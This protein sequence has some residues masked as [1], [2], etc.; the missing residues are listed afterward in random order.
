VL[1]LPAPDA[2]DIAHDDR[3]IPDCWEDDVVDAE[4]LASAPFV[5]SLELSSSDEASCE[6]SADGAGDV[7]RPFLASVCVA[8]PLPLLHAP[9]ASPPV[10]AKMHA[11]K[12][13]VAS[14]EGAVRRSSRIASKKKQ[15]AAKADGVAAVQELIARAC[16][17]IAKEGAFD[18]AAK[19]SYLRLFSSQLS[20][21]VIGAIEALIKQVKKSKKAKG[22]GK[23]KGKGKKGSSVSLDIVS[24]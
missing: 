10:L 14:D 7:L 6:C 5:P 17:A 15:E 19:A 13:R 20:A 8:V 18:D 1:L 23:A 16:G 9:A 24:L 4:P 12:K 21:P 11:R 22:N 3:V 2:H